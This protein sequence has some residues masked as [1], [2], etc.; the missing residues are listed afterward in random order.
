MTEQLSL[1]EESRQEKI[2]KMM[3]KALNKGVI[4][5]AAVILDGDKDN[6]YHV[7]HLGIGSGCILLAQLIGKDCM[8]PWNALDSRL[9]VLKTT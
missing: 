8:M 6:I 4:P 9:T 1:L 5:E 7:V 3:K 2:K